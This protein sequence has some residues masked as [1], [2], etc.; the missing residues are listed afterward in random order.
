M[1]ISK[2]FRI[3]EEYYKDLEKKAKEEHRSISNYIEKIL[4]EYIEKE[5]RK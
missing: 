3:A 2:S 1:K 5:I 4:I